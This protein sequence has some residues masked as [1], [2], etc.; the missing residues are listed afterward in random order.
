MKLLALVAALF[1]ALPARATERAEV[2]QKWKWDLTPIYSS[3]S[4]WARKRDEVAARIPKLADYQGKL[5]QS[6]GALYEG[7]NAVMGVDEDLTRL[8]IYAKFRGDEDTRANGPREMKESAEDLGVKDA[9]VTAYVRPEIIALGA[10][11]V[12]AYVASDPRLKPYGPWLDDLLRWAP[13]T[14]SPAEEKLVAQASGMEQSPE[15]IYGTFKDADLPYPE[16]TLSSGG[17]VRLDSQGYEKYRA[18]PVREDRD[19]VFHAFFGK[20]KEFERTFGAT[21]SSLIKTHLFDRDA[22]KFD[23][24]LSAAL[25]DSDV[26]TAVYHQLIADVHANLP[27]LHRYLKLR[28]RMMGLDQLRYEDLYAPLVG[29]VELKFTPEQA[30]AAV[31]AAVAPLGP[32]Y[33]A[34]LK[35][36]YEQRWVDMMP[37]TG[38]RPGAYEETIYGVH[39]YLL[40]NFSGLYQEVS[41]LAHESGHAMHSL[42]SDRTQPYA[43][44]NYKIFVAEVASTLN[45]NLLLHYMLG[46]TKDKQTRLA[47]LGNYLETLR[48]TLFRQTMF[49]EFEL[50]AHEMAEKGEPVTGEKLSALY[51]GLVKEYYGDAQGVCKVD[52]LYGVEWEY[53][54]HFYYD[55]YVFQYATS[56]VASS[57]IAALIRQEGTRS[58][59]ERDAY[60]AMLS[61]G[62]SKPP[63][64]ELR[65]AGVDLT[66]PEPFKAAIAEMNATMDE[67][68]KLLSSK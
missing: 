9:A 28:Q 23:S 16:I 24:T 36:A 47:L 58:H 49:A 19:K 54:P 11:K 67:M 63:M 15:N 48:T 64:D 52:D 62:S 55:Y 43:T 40:Q 44:H 18:S 41:T 38:K 22:R 32:S 45:E 57:R 34:D 25:F 56:I 37:S 3:D 35:K 12:H 29:K 66:S 65:G 10:D 50:R 21:L 7:L 60:L 46:R 61:M 31:I 13:H 33:Q 26:S 53:I 8:T 27:T 6:A 2:S 59:K 51:R 14:L 5:G 4:E 68:E 20:Y 1:I 39:P 42:L 17:V 30:Q